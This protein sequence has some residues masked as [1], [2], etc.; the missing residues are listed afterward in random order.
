MELGRPVNIFAT[1]ALRAAGDVNFPFYVGLASMWLLQ[2][3]GGYALG[4]YFALGINALWC[5]IAADELSL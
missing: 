1:N 3:L 2:V 4:I 5:M